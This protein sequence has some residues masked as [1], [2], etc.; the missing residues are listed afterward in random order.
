MEDRRSRPQQDQDTDEAR[1]RRNPA[2]ARRALAQ[3]GSRE[4]HD[5]HRRKEQDR[6]ALGQRQ[7]AQPAE[8]AYGCAK[9]HCRSEQLQRKP[10]SAPETASASMP[11][12]GRDDQH[13]ADV[14]GP[15]DEEERVVLNEVFRRRVERR[16]AEPREQKHGQSTPRV[17]F[18]DRPHDP[19]WRAQQE[20]S[21]RCLADSV[22]GDVERAET[23]V[24]VEAF[25]T[26]VRKLEI[27]RRRIPSRRLLRGGGMSRARVH[28][29]RLHCHSI[30]RHGDADSTRIDA[31]DSSAPSIPAEH[32]VLRR[33]LLRRRTKPKSASESKAASP[34]RPSPPC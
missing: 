15:D 1:D 9:Q 7:V 8:E 34:R 16:E 33:P 12:K 5:E 3:K 14:A 13:L 4:H 18:L 2:R 24:V 26:A 10:A 32:I 19:H 25:V 30:H 28:G 23:P 27:D 22:V 17:E 31:G 20:V 29:R 21:G 11:G 6:G